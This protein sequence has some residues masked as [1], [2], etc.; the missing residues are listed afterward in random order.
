MKRFCAF[1]LAGAMLFCGTLSGCTSPASSATA[2]AV[3]LGRTSTDFAVRLLQAG[4]EPGEN[5]LFSPVCLLYA[6]SMTANGA[7]GDTLDQMEDTLNSSVS[8]LNNDLQTYRTALPQAENCRLHL[9]N[10]L[11]LADDARL[12]VKP[13]FLEVCKT[14]YEAEV[15]TI[16]FNGSAPG[17]V[18]RWVEE[19]TDGMIPEILDEVPDTAVMY[20]LSAMAFDAEWQQKYFS[21]QP[22]V[23]TAETGEARDVEMMYGQEELYLED[24]SATG[25]LK[26]Y[27]DLRYAFAVLLPNEGVELD[28][29]IASLDGG[30]L[31]DLLND[32]QEVTVQTAIP[33]F[34]TAYSTELSG[35]LSEMGMPNAFDADRADFSRMGDTETGMLYISRVLHKT[36][37]SVTPRGTRAGA[38]ALVEMMFGGSPPA[39]TKQ[40]I[41]D[42]PFVYMILDR[43]AGVP[44][45][46]GVL[47]DTQE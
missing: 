26:P 2:L 39:A 7:D 8:Y 31:Y 42:R 43:Q 3:D 36:F 44:L 45:F 38:A 21:T 37:L 16:P 25:F 41:L 27:A 10:S 24:S 6:L 15:Q 19:N 5:V 35:V 29:Y 28:E 22:G 32:P 9:A 20:L 11:W 4:D 14:K 47:R 30:A 17:K 13:E 23:F 12:A 33:K 46:L 40:V 34:E 18:N 1:L